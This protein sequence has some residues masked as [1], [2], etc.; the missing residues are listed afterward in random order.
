MKYDPP[1]MTLNKPLKKCVIIYTLRVHKSYFK[2]LSLI[3]AF[4]LR[5][6]DQ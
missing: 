3:M 6:I 4:L 5:Q 2:C 1:E